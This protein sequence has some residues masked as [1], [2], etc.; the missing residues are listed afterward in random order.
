MG[1]Y[2]ISFTKLGYI[3]YTS[4]LDML[5]L[6]KRSFKRAGIELVYSQGFNPHPDMAFCQPLS[7]GY[8]SICE[9]LEFEINKPMEPE[10]IMTRL[11]E[12]MPKGISITSC[13]PLDDKMKSIA[14][15]CYEAS[16]KIEIPTID[17]C[18][19]STEDLLQQ[20][21]DQKQIVALKSSKKH[22]ETKELDIKPKIREIK[23]NIVD[24]I[25]IMYTRL[26]AGSHSNLSPELLI[27]SFCEF[28]GIEA[29]RDKAKI[30]RT[31]LKY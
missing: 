19:H 7:L 12:I 24:N 13:I 9:L 6:F 4:H 8:E 1:K 22:R 3:K 26:D 30:T 5:R 29:A 27:S 31:D 21:L 15:T 28:A 2:L 23:A 11:N 17:R 18:N 20:Y 10:K 14:S 16:Y 25:I